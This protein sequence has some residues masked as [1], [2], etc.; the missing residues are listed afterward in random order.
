MAMPTMVFARRSGNGSG[1][2]RRP[3]AAKAAAARAT[4]AHGI[5]AVVRGNKVDAGVEL[6]TARLAVVAAQRGGIWSGDGVRLE[7]L[8]R[9]AELGL[10]RRERE[11]ARWAR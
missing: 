10:A 3:E 4:R 1:S 6:G 5:T 9:A 11:K 2:K 7:A 8:R